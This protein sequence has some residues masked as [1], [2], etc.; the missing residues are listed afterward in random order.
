MTE[1]RQ[2]EPWLRGT[3]DEVPSVARAV[4]H[5]LQL[6]EEDLEKWCGALSQAELNARP[7][8]VA[9]VAFQIRHIARSVDRLLTYAEGRQLSKAQLEQLKSEME[10]SAEAAEIFSELRVQLRRAEQRIRALAAT[11]DLEAARS[12]GRR[13]LPTTVGGLLVHVAD[14]TQR[15][16][17][18]AITTAKIVMESAAEKLV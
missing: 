17:G 12:V 10:P 9:S 13:A 14:H 8:G 11:E 7:G 5:A 6:A 15:H 2:P 4:L 18:Q 16:T 1:T 3:L